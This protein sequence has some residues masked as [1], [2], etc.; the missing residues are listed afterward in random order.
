MNHDERIIPKT[1]RRITMCTSIEEI[2]ASPL[3][4]FRNWKGGMKNV[5]DCTPLITVKW[6]QDDLFFQSKIKLDDI[7]TIFHKH[8]V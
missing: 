5:L 4:E 1:T 8:A 7:N 6:Y 3:Q 2:W